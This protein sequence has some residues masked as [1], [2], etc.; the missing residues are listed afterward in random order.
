MMYNVKVIAHNS[1]VCYYNFENN[2]DFI[3]PYI[4]PQRSDQIIASRNTGYFQEDFA[5]GGF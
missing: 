5:A 1:C 2:V 4:P 3:Q